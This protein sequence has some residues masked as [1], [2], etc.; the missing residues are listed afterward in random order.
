M[1]FIALALA[2][3]PVVAIIIYFYQRD[4]YE[5]EPMA[6]LSRAFGFGV[7]SVIPAFMGSWFGSY[8]GFEISPNIWTTFVYAFF[9]V[10]LSEETA[11]FLFLRYGLFP[12]RE[13][14]E[15][16]DG[17]LYSVMVGMGFAATENIAY[18]ADGG[19][20]LALLRMFTAVPAH[21]TFGAVMGYYV[22]MAKFEP[23]RRTEFLL[24]GLGGAVFMHGLYD[25]FLMQLLYEG[26]TLGA[27]GSLIVS[28]IYTRK[29][30]TL[31]QQNSPFNPKNIVAETLPPTD[32]DAHEPLD[33]GNTSEAI[34]SN[35]D[36]TNQYEPGTP[37]APT[38]PI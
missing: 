7:L 23:A 22:G 3:A 24:K 25:F 1:L 12:R 15:P 14:D 37:P 16:Y 13:F 19:I 2:L 9:V 21:A 26:M 4:K 34:L 27:I 33:N 29:A 30:A 28:I 32:S 6:L 36:V 35:L 20:S 31:H 11:K 17:I 10:A 38:D 8:L 18:V 5:R